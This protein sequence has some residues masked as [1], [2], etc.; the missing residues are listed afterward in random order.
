MSPS[1][2]MKQ[3]VAILLPLVAVVAGVFGLIAARASS[4]QDDARRNVEVSSVR[5]LDERSRAAGRISAEQQAENSAAEQR[6]NA[7]ALAG[8]DAG[9]L[10]LRIERRGALEAA[11]AAEGASELGASHSVL[12][13]SSVVAERF[14]LRQ[15][16]G[17]RTAFEYAN[18]YDQESQ[19]LSEKFDSLLA[20][21]AVL[22]IGAFLVGLTLAVLQPAA[23]MVLLATGVAVSLVASAGGV[24]AAS[25]HVQ[26]P[27]SRA[28][29]A[30]VRGQELRRTAFIE[31]SAATAPNPAA[32]ALMRQAI[33]DFD[34]TIR[35]RPDYGAAYFGRALA[36]DLLA[37][38]DPAGP[39]GSADA[40]NDYRRANQLGFERHLVLNNLAITELRLG[41]IPAAIKAARAAVALRPNI[42]NANE[43]LA[44][45][46]RYAA[47]QAT[48]AY[49]AQLH[50]L[51][52]TWAQTDAKRRDE[53]LARSIK[54]THDIADQFPRFAS[55]ARA[56]RADLERLGMR[57]NRRAG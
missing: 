40:R 28:I 31:L 50:R 25:A 39:H 49:R 3:A 54:G 55:R 14:K 5:V 24:I 36:F 23:R 51:G 26:A 56:Y 32:R 22:A 2:A 30:Y 27:S 15:T 43:T 18:A 9:S 4:S 13:E 47:P 21:V 52:Q 44:S 53:E 34:E 17:A 57:L 1:P 41:D 19:L 38:T 42:S 7:R 12:R 37:S 33:G 6:A 35:L 20:V 11:R 16:R 10:D 46:L 48:P 8:R 29:N 45:V